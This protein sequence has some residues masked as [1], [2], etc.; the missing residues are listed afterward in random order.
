MKML[1]QPRGSCF[2]AAWAVRKSAHW[3]QND[4]LKSNLPKWKGIHPFWCSVCVCWSTKVLFRT[5]QWQDKTAL[6]RAHCQ[7]VPKT[8]YSSAEHQRPHCK[9]DERSSS[10]RYAVWDTRHPTAGN[11]LH[12]CREVGTS[13]LPTSWV[14]L[15]QEAWPCHVCPRATEI[16]AFG[17]ISTDIGDRVAV[18]G[19]WWL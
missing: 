4:K 17:P 16:H 7:Q 19:R 15:K 10:P 5:G 13:K 2:F 11:P 12:W 1:F 9:Q 6:F 14:L 3:C 8:N 18:C